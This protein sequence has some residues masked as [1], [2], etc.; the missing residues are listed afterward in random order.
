MHRHFEHHKSRTDNRKIGVE[1]FIDI[2]MPQY[3]KSYVSHLEGKRY[4]PDCIKMMPYSAL[5]GQRGR[6]LAEILEF[7]ER[8]VRPEREK[9]YLLALAHT[10]PG[11]L[12]ELE[13]YSGKTLAGDQKTSPEISSHMR[14]GEVG[15]FKGVLLKS[16]IEQILEYLQE[17]DITPEEFGINPEELKNI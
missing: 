13:L 14:G 9:A 15:K 5:I 11:V 10:E 12:R 8:P 3:I 2:A 1:E 6:S 7:F 4:F 16:Q 17:F